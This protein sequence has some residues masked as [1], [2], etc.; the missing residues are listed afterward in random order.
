MLFGRGWAAHAAESNNAA[1]MMEINAINQAVFG[2]DTEREILR[3]AWE[4]K[5]VDV[6][7]LLLT[8]KNCFE[9]D[10]AD[11]SS[12]DDAGKVSKWGP[13]LAPLDFTLDIRPR[14]GVGSFNDKLT[15]QASKVRSEIEESFPGML[16]IN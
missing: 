12:F 3:A 6:L 11:I 1:T 2:C 10:A 15:G 13:L 7:T 4:S 5:N 8:P 14:L 16:Y 9:V